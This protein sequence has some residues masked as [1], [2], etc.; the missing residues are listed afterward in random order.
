VNYQPPTSLDPL[1]QTFWDY[2][3]LGYHQ[4]ISM[5]YVL[6]RAPTSPALEAAKNNV[7]QGFPETEGKVTI[8]VRRGLEQ[9]SEEEAV[10]KIFSEGLDLLRSK[11][12]V[13]SVKTAERELMPALLHHGF[14]DGMGGIELM[15]RLFVNPPTRDF[16]AETLAEAAYERNERDRFSLIGALSLACKHLF[17]NSEV[18]ISK[19]PQ[20]ERVLHFLS[21]PLEEIRRH[22]KDLSVTPNT[23]YLLGVSAVLSLLY[24]GKKSAHALVPV[25][26]R[27]KNLSY[28][29][30]N[31]ILVY[32]ARLP[33]SG[34]REERVEMIAEQT[35]V[36]SDLSKLRDHLS[37]RRLVSRLPRALRLPLLKRLSQTTSCIATFVPQN[38]RPRFLGEARVLEQYPFPALLPGHQIGFGLCTYQGNFSIGIVTTKELAGR[39]PEL[40]A[41]FKEAV[42]GVINK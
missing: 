36:L 7:I 13:V 17:R 9:S 2:E 23:L 34:R 20:K 31:K 16:S 32:P 1:S 11:L 4:A 21:L 12:R 22:K 3:S 41:T 27:P 29:L 14:A 38:S 18:Q 33:L 30:G 35:K 39:G 6:D 5:L 24:P 26:L 19:A 8:E 10:S 25:N 42:L 40:K 15:K 37:A 28:T